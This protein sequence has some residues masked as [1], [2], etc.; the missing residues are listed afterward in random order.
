MSRSTQTP[1]VPRELVLL[2]KHG[3]PR[4]I[5]GELLDVGVLVEARGFDMPIL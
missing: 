4:M 3:T 2:L 1:V 5:P